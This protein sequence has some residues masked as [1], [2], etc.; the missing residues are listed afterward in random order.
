MFQGDTIKLK[1]ME[2]WK[3]KDFGFLSGIR[4]TLT[5]GELSPIFKSESEQIGPDIVEVD[6]IVRPKKFSL[7]KPQAYIRGL[8]LIGDENTT[9]CK[10]TADP[11]D[12]HDREI[13]KCIDE[14]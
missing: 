6:K 1:S 3:N 11:G 10:W 2:L 13:Q 14:D 9:L 12:K 4:V 8:S 7:K 5:N